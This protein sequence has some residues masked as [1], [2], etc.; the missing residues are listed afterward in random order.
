MEQPPTKRPRL[1]DPQEEEEEEE[2][3]DPLEDELLSLPSE[4]NARRDPNLKLE[5]SR[6]RAVFKLKSAFESIFERY[7][8]D[9]EGVG[10]EI[11]L[12]TGRIV[13]NNGHIEGM[14][15]SDLLEESEGD[16]NEEEDDGGQKENG[17]D[18]KQVDDYNDEERILQRG[19]KTQSDGR[20]QSRLGQD[21]M[22]PQ[23]MGPPR[24]DIGG[25]FG[26]W[27]GMMGGGPPGLPNM[28]FPGQMGVFNGWP[29]EYG[30]LM[31]LQVN[32]PT[33]QAPA[34]PPSYM[35]RPG[36]MAAAVPVKQK[37]MSLIAPRE[38]Q[39]DNEDDILQG[40]SAEGKGKDGAEETPIKQRLLVPKPPPD[41][42]S[43]KKKRGSGRRKTRI[44]QKVGAKSAVQATSP[45]QEDVADDT[46]SKP[47][48]AQV[49]VEAVAKDS[50]PLP[51]QAEMP[52]TAAQSDSAKGL[53][54]KHQVMAVRSRPATVK[55]SEPAGDSD[56]YIYMSDS[57]HKSARKPR[58]QSLRVEIVVK[59]P[60]DVTSFRAITPEH[61]EAES[62][63]PQKMD[64]EP[65]VPTEIP[66][67]AALGE[68]EANQP[69]RPPTPESEKENEAQSN[70]PEG[71]FTR[72]VV[73]PEYDFS[74]ENESMLKRR[75]QPQKRAGASRK[76]V[77]N[78][79]R[80][81]LPKPPN[82]VASETMTTSDEPNNVPMHDAGNLNPKDS[83]LEDQANREDEPLAVDLKE[84]S[85]QPVSPIINTESSI[86]D[87]MVQP[88]KITEVIYTIG[89]EETP[90]P[91]RRKGRPPFRGRDPRGEI[92]DSDPIGG[93]ST[94]EDLDDGTRP[95]SPSLSFRGEEETTLEIPGSYLEPSS[96]LGIPEEEP[97]Q[98]HT[99][100]SP[101]L[102]SYAPD[103]EILEH[104]PSLSLQPQHTEILEPTPTLSSQPLTHEISESIPVFSSQSHDGGAIAETISSPPP[105]TPH[106]D[107]KPMVESI[108]TTSSPLIPKPAQALSTPSSR[109]PRA[110]PPRTK[111]TPI[112]K[113]ATA[114]ATRSTKTPAS[115][116]PAPTPAS[117]SIS[118]TAKRKRRSGLS[119]LSPSVIP[120]VTPIIR[121]SPASHHRRL[122]QFF[123]QQD[124]TPKEEGR[125][126]PRWPDAPHGTRFQNRSVAEEGEEFWVCDCGW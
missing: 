16:D 12:R 11:D 93:S 125:Q 86:P 62:S 111:S 68:E 102:S 52:T 6:Q 63:D 36:A 109:R 23:M 40:V 44:V 7:G 108:E 98:D 51:H 50:G 66:E 60:I 56:L 39:G 57:E 2:E 25:G 26:G 123:Q 21:M 107:N 15:G 118:S 58:N 82:I 81:T 72:H 48:P 30:P 69:T 13:V 59:R 35:H 77:E 22:L 96:E 95:P 3:E 76:K 116:P 119:L 45:I 97:P 117:T 28:M 122:A 33:W 73:N 105:H 20:V 100:P 114:P 124:S 89:N 17:R 104:F 4:V 88:P 74:D 79:L 42:G 112:T 1:L 9:F 121:S 54:T 92:P 49:D 10:D 85:P 31:N 29:V 80:K 53:G 27:P 47:D 32:D 113:A 14:R 41:T 91:K 18:Q 101:T 94:Q 106:D 99:V 78:L 71:V 8:R 34:L 38:D 61:S 43:G 64:V 37:R 83:G 120:P 19:A 115:R 84:P 90:W 126:Q 5:R 55:D 65:A 67:A 24:L 87:N 75:R 46:H 110:R 103:D 70:S